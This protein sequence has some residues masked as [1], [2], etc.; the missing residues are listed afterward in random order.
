MEQRE[1][2]TCAEALAHQEGKDEKQSLSGIRPSYTMTTSGGEGRDYL[3]PTAGTNLAKIQVYSCIRF[4]TEK[5]KPM[6][7]R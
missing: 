7:S 6:P 3:V 2:R 5:R 1:K 4:N